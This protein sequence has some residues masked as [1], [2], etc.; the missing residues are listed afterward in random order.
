MTRRRREGD[1]A[2][3]GCAR[4]VER[5]ASVGDHARERPAS[6]AF[7]EGPPAEGLRVRTAR[8]AAV[9]A[10]SQAARQI[11]QLGLMAV[12]AR[13]LLPEDYG[14]VG[15]VMALTA[16]ASVF[17]HLG[18]SAATIQRK[19]LTHEQVSTLFWVNAGFGGFLALVVGG[20]SPAIAWFYGEPELVWITMAVGAGFAIVGLGVQHSAL[21]TRR[22]RFGRMAGVEIA[23]LALGGGAGIVAALGGWGPYALVAQA[24][25]TSAFRTAG[26]WIAC[27]WVP[28][29]P[30]RGSGARD[31]V[32][33]GGYLAG[34]NIV[35]YFA[36]NM[37]KVLLGFFWGP[38]SVG[39]YERA[40]RLMMYPIMTTTQPMNRVA[41]P[42]LS[43]LQDDREG[44]ARA[45]LRMMRLL[46]LV[47]FPLAGGL[48]VMA[49][50]AVLIVFGPQWKEAI[51]IFRILCI[52]GMF[53]AWGSSVA[54]LYVSAG[55]TR[56]M[57][58]W[59][60]FASPLVVAGL[61]PCV[62]Y[63]AMGAAVGYTAV[64][65]LL[66]PAGWWYV[67]RSVGV[68]LIPIV[69]AGAGPLAAT[70]VMCAC[71]YLLRTYAL[72]EVPLALRALALVGAGVV[73]FAFAAAVL[74]LRAVRE[75]VAMAKSVVMT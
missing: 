42:A 20:A 36:R 37:N 13:L 34:S 39:L 15:M 40:Y 55:K 24:T 70:G 58:L 8:G 41:V 52:A 53:E 50:E 33:F 43:K 26:Y 65:G 29:P 49:E 46:A 12:L 44:F 72:A 68:E 35:S 47:S 11:V 74:A 25:A 21:L 2:D 14:L 7:L 48:A 64:T 9:V 38:V 5:L 1:C 60:A 28:G 73:S 67:T 10:A 31:L 23:S 56:N 32:R 16:L 17:A 61:L 75:T 57:F 19:N 3:C 4:G 27:G 54:W 30:V 45:H 18:L 63:G 62:W 66:L 51:P 6:D 69:R 59:W 22:M 71:V